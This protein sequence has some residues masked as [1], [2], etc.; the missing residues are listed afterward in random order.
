MRYDVVVV[1]AGPAGSTTA[2]EC[3]ARGMSV[4]MLDKA[5]FP[6]V[7]PCGGGVT[8]RAAGLLPFDISPVVERVANSMSFTFKKTKEFV[9]DST[10]ELAYLTQRLHLDIFLVERALEKGATLREKA[11]IKS[12]TWHSAYFAIEAAGQTIEGRTLVAADGANGPTARMAGVDVGLI[13]GIALEANVTPDGGVPERWEHQMGFDLGGR[14]GGYG[15]N[16]P[17]GDHLN[18]GVGG[19][20][21]TGPGLRRELEDLVRF[22][23]YDPGGM[24]GVQGHHIPMRRPDS[25]LV[26]GNLVLVGDAAGFIDPLTG[27]GIYAGIFSGMV[28]AHHLAEYVA[29]ETPDLSGYQRQIE[30]ELVPDL[31]A[32]LKF[33]D[34]FHLIP[35]LIVGLERHTST[36]SGSIRRLLRG[37][38][39]YDGIRV[40]LGRVWTL[41]EFVS[42]FVRTSS[43]LQRMSGLREPAMPE[44]FFLGGASPAHPVRVSRPEAAPDFDEI[45]RQPPAT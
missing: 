39:T 42:D 12:V 22:Y 38:Q 29:G 33:H 3:A 44:R 7:K 30:A 40:K 15:W 27:E 20:R 5:E 11:P 19:W 45:L 18:I 23:G 34:V 36:L 1:G 9:R 17:K 4:V 35:G 6:R 43:M 24:W 31:N 16:F 10:Q 32:S 2:R 13:K 26:R 21:Y 25:P 8:V 37:E 14:P 28:A 41:V